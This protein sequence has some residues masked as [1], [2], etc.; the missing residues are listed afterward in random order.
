MNKNRKIIITGGS[1]FLGTKIS[2]K[3]IE[4]GNYEVI[5]IDLFPPR[6]KNEKISFYKKNL[7]ENWS[8]I[9]EKIFENTHSVIHLAGKNIFERFTQKHK[10]LLW[11]TRVKTT[12]NLVSFWK[13]NE[14]ARPQKFIA[15]S[16]T[17]FYGEHGSEKISRKSNPKN[18]LFL[19]KLVKVWEEKILATE[20]LHI[21][22]KILRNA[23]IMGR[24]GML[25]AVAKNFRFKIGSYLGNGQSFMPWVDIDDAVG[26]YIFAIQNNLEENIYNVCT[27]SIT[28]KDF[29]GAI[30][31]VKNSWFLHP[32]PRF[33]LKIL[34]G[35]FADEMLM[36]QNIEQEKIPGFSFKHPSIKKTIRKYLN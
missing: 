22:T 32:A 7:L 2:E 1:G 33:L 5:I 35:S 9:E 28:Q 25:G 34:F 23:H 4:L 13:K 16:A 3:L 12:E 15:A 29:S 8:E 24:G 6:I 19:G 27:G 18:I 10:D 36:S 30:A 26:L 11:K 31:K 21:E 17:G 20:K 14:C